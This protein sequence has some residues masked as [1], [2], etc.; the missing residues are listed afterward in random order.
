MPVGDVDQA[1]SASWPPAWPRALDAVIGA[2]PPSGEFRAVP[3]DFRVE[4]MLGFA[5]EGEGEHLWLW[6]EKRGVTTLELVRHLARACEVT[7]R[8]IG[9]SG[10][11]DKVAVTRQWISVHLPGREAPANLTAR[12]AELPVVLLEQVRHPRKLKRGVHRANRFTLRL[13]G[14][15]ARDPG[16]E[17]RWRWLCEHG[18]PNYFGPQ[19]FGPGGRN[20]IRARHLLARGWRKRDDREGMLLSAA[21]SYLFNTLLAKRLESGYWDNAMHGDILVLDGTNSQFLAESIDAELSTRLREMDVHPSGVLWGSGSLASRAQA[22]ACEES[23]LSEEPELC[24]G[25]QHAGVRMARRA[26]RVRL[27]PRAYTREDSALILGFELPV[28]AF[29]TSV[30]RELMINPSL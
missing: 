1:R 10:M 3:E 19:R 21:R 15:A 5:P 6:V 26:L 17:R 13:T 8:D 27:Q 25:L 4:E 18:V 11:K 20:L 30:L 22:A 29:A 9:Y 28:G 12:L 23:L 14:D 16:V 7:P 2:A 24:E